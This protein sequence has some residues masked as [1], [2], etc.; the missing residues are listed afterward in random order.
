M[1]QEGF[2]AFFVRGAFEV[3]GQMLTEFHEAAFAVALDLQAGVVEH[4][5]DALFVG[6]W[7]EEFAGG[8]IG[9]D[10][11]G[12][13]RVSEHAS[14][15][16]Y[17]IR[18]TDFERFFGAFRGGDIAVHEEGHVR[19]VSPRI[20]DAVPVG[21]AAIPLFAGTA[22]HREEV[23]ACIGEHL[24]EFETV[25]VFFPA[26]TGL[27]AHGARNRGFHG[28][29]DG[30][31]LFWFADKRSAVEVR[32]EVVDRATH[33]HVDGIRLEPFVDNAGR[34]GH[35]GRIRAKNLLYKR[36]FTFVERRHFE[37]FGVQANNRFR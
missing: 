20:A 36:P 6:W 35:H 25:G 3:P 16:Q 28:S 12:E 14:A 26:E 24:H 33:V 23:D 17:S 32:N 27:H 4:G 34:F 2:E 10:A 31:R 9:F 1:H 8:E 37:G 30:M 21:D 13:P 18:T 19:H 11:L 7:G 15:N 29:D 22:V 5:L